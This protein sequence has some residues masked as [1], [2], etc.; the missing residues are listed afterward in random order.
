M[1]P[2]VS[3]HHHHPD[4][5]GYIVTDLLLAHSNFSDTLRVRTDKVMFSHS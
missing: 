5:L 3:L 4:L 1:F 2:A